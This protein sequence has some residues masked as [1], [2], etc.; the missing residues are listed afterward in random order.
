MAACLPD[1]TL[2]L[3]AGVAR[4]R[5]ESGRQPAPCRD[6]VGGV[7]AQRTAPTAASTS[8]AGVLPWIALGVVYVV[9]GSTYLGIR[10][11]VESMPPLTSAGLR[12]AVAGVLL[13]VV[14]VALRGWRVLRMSRAQLGTAVLLGFLLPAWGNGLVTVAEQ[15]TASGLAALL[16]ASVPLYIVLLRLLAGDRPRR[17]TLIGVAVGMAGLAVMLLAGRADGSGGTAGAAWWGP[18]L[19]LVAALGW[20]AGSFAAAR[21]PAP[22]NPFALT[23]V[24]MLAGGL[25]M[26]VAGVLRGERLDLAAVT[27]PSWAGWT[28]LVTFGSIGAFSSYVYV[29]GRLPVSTVATYAYVNPVIAVLLGA[30]IAG[31]R[32]GLVQLLGGALVVL[33]VVVVIASERRRPPNVGGT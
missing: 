18:W 12:F 29:L 10:Y 1:A 7:T 9:W 16:I 13:G 2:W 26:V 27:A 31:E 25:I 30:L 21:M 17:S 14:L 4:G 15:Q 33:A 3:P 22:P 28:F 32:F 20:A 23:V 6:N 19:V 24:E 8:S 5:L 11:M